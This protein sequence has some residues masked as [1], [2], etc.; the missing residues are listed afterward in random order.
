MRIQTENKL[1]KKIFFTLFI[2]TVKLMDYC[3]SYDQDSNA[4][5]GYGYSKWSLQAN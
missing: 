4:D 3:R 2:I 1:E 5:L